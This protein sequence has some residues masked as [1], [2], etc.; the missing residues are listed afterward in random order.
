MVIGSCVTCTDPV[1]SQA[2]AKG[3]FADKF[4]PRPVREII[5]AE[6]AS[7]DGFGFPFLMLATYLIRHANNPLLIQAQKE[8][9]SGNLIHRAAELVTRAEDVSRIGGGV[10]IALKHWLL[11]TW[12]YFVC[13]SIIYGAVVGYTS[14]WMVK[15]AL[16]R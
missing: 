3:P 1:L 12:L 14:L 8:V 16:R 2:V 15:Y 13:L 6:A 11:E 10:G 7:N 9:T 4:V 5:S